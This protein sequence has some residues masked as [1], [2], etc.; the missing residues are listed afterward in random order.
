MQNFRFVRTNYF[1]RTTAFLV[2]LAALGLHLWHHEARPV[3]WVLLVL[4]FAVYPHVL[5]LRARYSATPTPAPATLHRSDQNRPCA[6]RFS[7]ELSVVA[8]M[9]P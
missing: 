5:Y 2:C 8:L 7:A 4:Q 1:V 6:P 9:R 3:A